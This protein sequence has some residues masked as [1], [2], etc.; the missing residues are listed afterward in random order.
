M[1][2]LPQLLAVLLFIAAPALS[3]Q[4]GPAAFDSREWDFGA[5]READGVVRHEFVVFNRSDR[6]LRL[7]RAIPGCS[8]IS[9]RLPQGVLSPGQSAA[10]EV[11]F[12]PA[13]AAGPVIRTVEIQAGG[14][15]SL[16]IL[17]ISADVLPADRSIQERYP[18]VLAEGLYASR[19]E[20]NFGYLERG[21]QTGKV[22]FV[23]NASD[24]P[25][26][27]GVSGLGGTRFRAVCPEALAPGEEARVEIWCDTPADP[28]Y[29]AS[30]HA[31]LRLAP[32]GGRVLR[33]VPLSG[34]CLTQAPDSPDAP[35]LR[36]D[37]PQLR[38]KFLSRK[39]SGTLTLHND[40]ATPLVIHAI[41]LP[42]G[43]SVQMSSRANPLS[44]RA[45]PR[46]LAIAPGQ[47]LKLVLTAPEG[48]AE[49]AFP[50]R[51]EDAFKPGR[52]KPS[53]AAN[54]LRMAVF[55]NDP[56]RPCKEIPINIL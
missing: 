33:E 1:G 37:P 25:M 30:L 29:F 55:T 18:V 35:R 17:S 39:H 7:L 56:L 12:T 3:A 44:S 51:S 26:R 45:K 31:S 47:T 15:V 27:L 43:F 6:P 9:A 4:E 49:R 24:K 42:E 52:S 20:V 50:Q 8:C 2:R 16:G 53:G 22:L 19:S 13:G 28:A 11:S 5:I 34:L 54:E 36:N 48:S 46:D 10:V 38:R 23:A 32:Q 40:G 14:G 41:E 21:R